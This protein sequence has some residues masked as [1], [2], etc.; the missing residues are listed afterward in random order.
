MED[1]AGDNMTETTMRNRERGTALLM[2]IV[3]A[4]IISILVTAWGSLTITRTHRVR[5]DESQLQAFYSA[6]AGIQKARHR[7]EEDPSWRT[8]GVGERPVLDTLFVDQPDLCALW[9]SDRGGFAEVLS[10]G[11]KGDVAR[12]ITTVFGTKLPSAFNC[13]A[14]VLSPEPLIL[15][16][17]GEIIGD[18]KLAG[19]LENRGGIHDGE[20]RQETARPNI[21]A[22]PFVVTE[23]ECRDI[24]QN[25][26]KADEEIFSPQL[27]REGNPPP[28]EEGKVFYVNDMIMFEGG[29]RDKPLVFQGPGTI[30]SIGDIQLAEYVRLTGGI[31]LVAEGVIKLLDGAE[32]QD[33]L[34]YGRGGVQ[35][36][37]ESSFRGQILSPSNILITS[38]SRIYGPST[39]FLSKSGGGPSTSS[40]NIEMDAR[41]TATIYAQEPGSGRAGQVRVKIKHGTLVE[42]FVYCENSALQLEGTLWGCAVV[43]SFFSP[44]RIVGDNAPRNVFDQGT[45]VRDAL[46]PDFV[47]PLCFT[48]NLN[49]TPVYWSEIRPWVYP[50]DLESL[51]VEEG[52]EW[53][54]EWEGEP[55]IF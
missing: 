51:L 47:A 39:I 17:G 34:I 41:V 53:E 27:Y 1:T 29:S 13:A 5:L 32:I 14:I 52:D 54:E 20:W 35:L 50:A 37:D 10:I 55:L 38:Q 19:R 48:S 22:A 8:G 36:T 26:Y 49:Y 9:C 11:Q 16:S 40:I 6:E 28:L 33:G 31:R 3:L 24:L 7:L 2:A 23:T 43:H 25:P 18:L 46:S 45:I 4:F 42:G 44:M 12:G 30:A 21:T 15:L